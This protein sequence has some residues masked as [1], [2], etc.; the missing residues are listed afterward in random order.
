MVFCPTHKHLVFLALYGLSACSFL[1]PVVEDTSAVQIK[2]PQ[3]LVQAEYRYDAWRWNSAADKRILP[4]LNQVDRFLQQKSWQRAVDKLEQVIDI[5]PDYAPAWSRLA[6]IA[7]QINEP[8]QTVEMAS[9]SNKLSYSNPELQS[10]NWSF[11]KTA[12]KHLDDEAMYQ[13]ATQKIQ[14]LKKF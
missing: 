12:S 14:S 5:Q 2:P 4:L 3:A 7:L 8:A 10:L 11:I 6:W 9:R 1:N 13:Q